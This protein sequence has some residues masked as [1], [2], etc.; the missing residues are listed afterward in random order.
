MADETSPPASLPPFCLV[1]LG[2]S[3]FPHFERD[4]HDPPHPYPCVQ[5]KCGTESAPSEYAF[6]CN[7]ADSGGMSGAMNWLGGTGAGD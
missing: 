2:L 6:G 5:Q 7:P 3:S 4:P 1:F